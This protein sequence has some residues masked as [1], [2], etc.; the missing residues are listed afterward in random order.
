MLKPCIGNYGIGIIQVSR[1]DEDRYA[2]QTENIKMIMVGEQAAWDQIEKM[3]QNRNYIVQQRIPL[4][5]I[6]KRPFDLRIV[7]RRK[8]RN[9]SWIVTGMFAKVAE[10]GYV[11]T[12]VS[13]Q[14]IPV[15]QA[16]EYSYMKSNSTQKLIKKI[17][18]ICLSAAK[19]LSVYYP[20]NIIGFDIGLDYDAHVWI[21]EA[22]FKPSMKP[23]LLIK[24]KNSK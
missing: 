2:I 11:V 7:V 6:E 3:V 8:K 10:E 22:N 21:I 19:H 5:Q 14:M 16:I 17:N 9:A 23:F 12:N 24:Y 18:K 1:L 15:D 20:T 13:S 4:A